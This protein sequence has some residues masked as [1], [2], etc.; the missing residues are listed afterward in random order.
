MT[1]DGD[2]ALFMVSGG[3]V[4]TV[5]S[6]D[7]LVDPLQLDVS[8][9]G[10]MV[11]VVDSLAADG[12]AKLIVFDTSTWADTAIYSGFEL[13]F[14]GGVT[15]DDAGGMVYATTLGDPSLVSMATDGSGFEVL[16][17]MGVLELP[18]G[19]AATTDTV[20]LAESSSLPGTDLYALT[21]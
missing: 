10:A 17:T 15:Y 21:W 6:G 1:S 5:L 3:S 7:P 19:I 12:K 13:N 11:F 18:A 9:D 16:D 4:T 14:P 8:D 20:Y 2:P